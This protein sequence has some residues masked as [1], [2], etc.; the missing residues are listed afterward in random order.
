LFAP[1]TAQGAKL[2]AGQWMDRG[3]PILKAMDEGTW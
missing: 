3:H 1:E 2:D